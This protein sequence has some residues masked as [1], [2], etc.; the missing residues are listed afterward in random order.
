MGRTGGYLHLFVLP[1]PRCKLLS[2]GLPL[3][4]NLP[5]YSSDDAQQEKI[6]ALALLAA[7]RFLSSAEPLTAPRCRNHSS[8]RISA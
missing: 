7:H 3:S 4:F 5:V 6:A 8:V 1:L 2:G